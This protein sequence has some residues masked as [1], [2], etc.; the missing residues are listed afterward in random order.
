MACDSYTWN[1]TVYTTSTEATYNTQNAA[2]CDSVATLILT[3]NYSAEESVEVTLTD[4]ELPYTYEGENYAEFGTY[5]VALTTVAGCDSTVHLTLTRTEGI[6]DA[7]LLSFVKVYPNP[8]TG[9]V[10]INAEQVLKVEVLDLVGREVARFEN[11][12][13]IDLTNLAAGTYTL[14]LTL[15]EGTVLRKVVK[16]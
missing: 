4:A 11:S 2:G 7:D 8:T 6:D 5:D 9:R 3:I 1:G 10:Q 16:R 14:R 12:T 13:T 15:P